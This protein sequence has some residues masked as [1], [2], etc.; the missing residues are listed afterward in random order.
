MMRSIHRRLAWLLP[1]LVWWLGSV[2]VNAQDDGARA[3]QVTPAGVHAFSVYGIFTR[4]NKSLDPGSVVEG[5]DVD[6]NVSVLQYAHPLT[7][8][9][10]LS[11]AFVVVPV[12][13]VT[14]SLSGPGLLVSGTSSGLGDVQLGWLLNMVGPPPATGKEFVALR[15]GLTISTLAKLTAPTGDYASSRTINLGAHRWGLQLGLPLA[16]Y[17]GDSYVDARLTTF[18]LVPSV[19]WFGTNDQPNG[20]DRVDQKPLFRLEGHVTH[21]LSPKFWVSLDGLFN[22]GAETETDGVDDQNAQSALA[23]GGTAAGTLTPHVILKATY[24]GVVAR[25]ASGGDGHMFRVIATVVF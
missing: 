15:P 2:A 20:A 23:L 19:T 9:G 17:V 14:G 24:G 10:K 25:N 4:G 11:G 13:Q 7:I 18:E 8:G 5:A 12:G 21:N 6:V 22:R 3:Y 1:V 16:Y